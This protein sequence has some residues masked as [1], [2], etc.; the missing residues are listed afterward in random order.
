M[1]IEIA[2]FSRKIT[3]FDDGIHPNIEYSDDIA[4]FDI[5]PGLAGNV[6]V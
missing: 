4:I 5:Q 3:T 2:K 6:A 1:V